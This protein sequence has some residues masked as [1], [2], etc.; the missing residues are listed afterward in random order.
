MQKA[1]MRTKSPDYS[2]A[3]FQTFIKIR[4]SFD[5][6]CPICLLYT[7]EEHQHHTVENTEIHK[8]GQR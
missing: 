3:I 4:L 5:C 1:Y 6:D 2:Q 7:A 8:G